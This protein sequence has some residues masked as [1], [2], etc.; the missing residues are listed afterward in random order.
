M[1]FTG[2]TPI[3]T[4]AGTL[5]ASVIASRGDSSFYGFTWDG[6]RI[7][8]GHAK[9]VETAAK[10]LMRVVLDNGASL[11]LSEDQLV[12]HRD[13]SE[14]VT[15]AQEGL[16]VMALYL[17]RTTLG[18]PTYRQQGVMWRNALAPS[19]RRRNRLVA[20]MVY[21]WKSKQQIETGLIVRFE[22][23]NRMNCSPDNLRIEGKPKK[24]RVRGTLKGHIKTH[25]QIEKLTKGGR[26]HK[27]VGWEPW[28]HEEEVFDL[29][30]DQCS[31]LAVG[32]V[33]VAVTDVS[34]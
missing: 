16:S 24:G 29:V 23:G 32:E 34:A 14:A 5:L 1:S 21:E 10:P 19:D 28:P 20:R 3:P 31:N 2:S 15:F 6:E 9:L 26:N 18:Y 7:N 17:G 8:V 30:S 11:L 27:I 33:F 4:L 22:D 25:K 12:I 13:T